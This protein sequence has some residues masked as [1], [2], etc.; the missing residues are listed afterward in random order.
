M[1]TLEMLFPREGLMLSQ[2]PID[3]KNLHLWLGV[4]A[5]FNDWVSRRIKSLELM[6]GIDFTLLRNEYN[7]ITDFRVS[8]SIAKELGMAERTKKGKEV[9]K[10]F[11]A[12]ERLVFEEIPKLHAELVDMS[13]KLF[14]T[15]N[16]LARFLGKESRP[17]KELIL[18]VPVQLPTLDGF[19]PLFQVETILP[20][21]AEDPE[22]G[23]AEVYF[24][25]K[26]IEGLTKKREDIIER[27]GFTPT[28]E[29]KEAQ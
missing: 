24:T 21:T 3:A 27:I 10:Y 18:R 26:Q 16:Q 20:Q 9:R 2:F 13:Q 29:A 8:M 7:D 22:K 15:Q 1:G 19:P 12:C 28:F 25:E 11:L 5:R 6:E 4:E 14:E 23:I 17:K